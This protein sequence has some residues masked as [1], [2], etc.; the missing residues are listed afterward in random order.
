MKFKT[1]FLAFLLTL[2][3]LAGAAKA[4]LDKVVAGLMWDGIV[5]ELSNYAVIRGDNPHFS[6][7]GNWQIKNATAV[8]PDFGM[9]TIARIYSPLY[10]LLFANF[11]TGPLHVQSHFEQAQFQ[12]LSDVSFGYAGY[13]LT[14]KELVKLMG[15]NLGIERVDLHLNLKFPQVELTAVL[16]NKNLAQLRFSVQLIFPTA[17]KLADLPKQQ[18]DWQ[19]RQFAFIYQDQGLLREILPYLAKRQ[20]TSIAAIQDHFLSQLNSEIRALGI[21]LTDDQQAALRTFIYPQQT[22]HLRLQPPKPISLKELLHVPLAEWSNAL[23]LKL[24][25][26]VN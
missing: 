5:K 1:Y 18:M 26:E 12:P 4:F 3:M 13:Q 9:F 25:T 23:G 16:A 8:I 17:K 10:R 14:V 2:A 24:S 11:E 20:Q 22:L 19:L 15:Q 6:L 7:L 21:L